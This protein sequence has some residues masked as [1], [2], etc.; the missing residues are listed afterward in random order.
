MSD[1]R[2]H[3][4]LK[5]S[6]VFAGEEI[7][8]EI[9]FRNI[10]KSSGTDQTLSLNPLPQKNSAPGRGRWKES[11]P[12]QPNKNAFGHFH[13][14]LGSFAKTSHLSAGAQRSNIS[15]SSQTGVKHG[16]G[17]KNQ[18]CLS[19]EDVVDGQKHKRSVSIVSMGGEPGS[20]I[21]S[22]KNA[23]SQEPKRPSRGHARAASLQVLPRMVGLDSGL[24][25]SKDFSSLVELCS[26]SLGQLHNRVGRT[27][28]PLLRASF[29]FSEQTLNFNVATAVK[30][31]S[32]GLTGL[33][34]LRP[35]SKVSEPMFSSFRFPQAPNPINEASSHEIS[36]TTSNSSYP[37]AIDSTNGSESLKPITRILSPISMNCT[38]RSSLEFYT[39]S[40]NSTE[41]LTSEYTAQDQFRVSQNGSHDLSL[42]GP[43][44]NG[45]AVETLMMGYG[46]VTGSFTIDSS[47]VSHAHF[48]EVKRKA[49]IGSQGGGGVVRAELVKQNGGL[50][51]GMGWGTIGESLGGLLRSNELSSIKENKDT[52]S[53][54][55]IPILSTPQSVLFVNLQLGQGE[56]R[57]YTYR[58]RIPE[59]VPP[60]HRGKAMKVSYN[61]TIGIQRQVRSSIKHH[62]RTVDIP[63]KVLTGVNGKNMVHLFN[64]F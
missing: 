45:N 22:L 11:L 35:L 59:G 34:G 7:E 62:V 52:A 27:A 40:N 47:L 9:T 14:N 3:V 25:C 15:L 42:L 21:E 4:Q 30:S 1:M 57:S 61:L 41:T 33:N 49:I 24:S 46:Q 56:S 6:S 38:P 51:G 48:D 55:A 58:H 54:R 63:F 23:H 44:S 10:S 60:T 20:P 19:S 16:L 28:S 18:G 64:Q 5:N 12:L 17:P 43:R 53:A 31:Q 39:T 26:Q 2:V 50:F 8:C 13:S 32:S 37:R 36:S 29:S